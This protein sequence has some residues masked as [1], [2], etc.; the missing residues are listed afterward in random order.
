[1]LFIV[2]LGFLLSIAILFIHKFIK[3]NW[4]WLSTLIPLTSF[5]YFLSFI[6]DI[7][8][9]DV[10]KVS[11]SWISSYSVDLS[12]MLDGLSL[13]FVLMIS[14][15]GT[16]VFWYT[17]SYL[18]GHEYLDRFYAYLGIFMAAMLGLV[19]S[20]NLITMFIFW[21][22]TSI[23]SF[24]LIGFNNE[25]KSSRKSALLALG[26]TGVGGLFLLAAAVI[27]GQVT[28]TYTISEMLSM[29]NEIA[30]SSSYTFIVVMIF[31]AAFTKSAQ[32]P[33][34]FWL[35]GAMKAPTPVSTYLHSATMVKAGIYLILRFSPI[36]GE[37]SLWNTTLITIG[38]ITM[39]Y[40]AIQMLFRTDLKAILAYSTI[41]ALGIL[42]FLTGLGTYE[43]LVAAMVFIVVHALYKASLFLITGIIDHETGTRD[44]TKLSGLKQGLM[45]IAV[46]GF[47]AALISG[48]V[49]PT[50]GF[51]GKDLIYESTLHFKNNAW[52]LTGIAIATNVLLF[53]GGFLVGVKP[54]LGKKP[55]A[56][57]HLHMPS[58]RLW[59]PPMLMVLL[60]L[61]LGFMPYL[62][63]DS[64]IMPGAEVLSR[65]ESGL[66]LKL[67][68]GF[69]TMF[70]LSTLTIAFGVIVYLVLKPSDKL[71]RFSEKFE[72][73][74]PKSIT[75][76]LVSLFKIMSKYWT[77]LFQN[78]YLRHY[79]ATYVTFIIVLVGYLL[80]KDPV[81]KI[82]YNTL[83]DLTVYEIVI[84]II[85]F[86]S[87]LF[88]VFTPSRLAAVAAM[89]IIGF[90]FCLLYLFYSAPDLAMTQFSV[91]TLTVILFVLVLYR[92][93]KYL[94]FSKNYLRVEH[95]ILS[96]IFGGMITFLILKVISEPKNSE[97]SNFYAENS[98]V[99]AKG[100]N[101][102]NV[103]LVDF[104]GSDT[105]IEIT[106]LIVAA[107]G[108]FGLLK[109]RLKARDKK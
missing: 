62:L 42:T 68:H 60:G 30:M 92:L 35:P 97:I 24:F 31:L 96:T 108:V 21:E 52:L 45:P 70:W 98:Y 22:L 101:V 76:Y 47:V 46:A 44:I 8:Q 6:G 89:G 12:F 66:H 107:I 3:G 88:T 13:L 102:V 38:A 33:F 18:K 27:L 64:L 7:A 85:M 69:N 77:M 80:L 67:W 53:Y 16:L 56:L 81:L 59:L 83:A 23:S 5:L 26:I 79:V 17:S 25:S 93:P 75:Q 29:S 40:S 86:L 9:N 72:F 100:K 19:L 49:I 41:C 82:D 48:G 105:L 39:L 51:V 73:I 90:A 37:T 95:G 50:L 71:L 2:C 34:H 94:K 106:V 103:I 43:A 10:I 4:A 78:G 65:G 55:E 32:F 58:I 99:L 36:L 61:V 11:Y 87:T 14:G 28:S 57:P 54:F 91:D 63:G 74:S 104:R 15:I 20:D 1:M 109:L 84:I